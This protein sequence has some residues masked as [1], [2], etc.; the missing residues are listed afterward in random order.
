MS[1]ESY[2]FKLKGVGKINN[3]LLYLEN[4]TYPIH[5]KT[6]DFV[7]WENEDIDL[8]VLDMLDCKLVVLARSGTNWS[9]SL[10]NKAS[11]KNVWPEQ[12]VTGEK[13]RNTSFRAKA[14]NPK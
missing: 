3:V 14:V 12:G 2:S 8:E 7:T 4:D 13:Y 10:T 5:L 6:N 11:G 9:S 1:N